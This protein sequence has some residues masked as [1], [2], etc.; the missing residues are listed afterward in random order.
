MIVE[1]EDIG[2]LGCWKMYYFFEVFRVL[3]CV[4]RRSRRSV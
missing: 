2:S 1:V 4:E 3:C